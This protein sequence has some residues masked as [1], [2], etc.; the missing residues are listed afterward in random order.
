MTNGIGGPHGQKRGGEGRGK[1][2]K[3]KGAKAALKRKAL[4]PP[5]LA[6]GKQG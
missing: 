3:G 6:K 2:A 4:I 1:K 5:A